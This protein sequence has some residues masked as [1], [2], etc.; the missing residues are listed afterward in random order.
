MY[1][2]TEKDLTHREPSYSFR[3]AVTVTKEQRPALSY[4]TAF[5]G[6]KLLR[7]GS[8]AIALSENGEVCIL[9]RAKEA[10]AGRAAARGPESAQA[11]KPTFFFFLY[12]LSRRLSPDC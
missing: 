1:F 5:E 8:T 10:M 9:S 7:A 12:K 2:V 6:E 4:S 11:C 3:V